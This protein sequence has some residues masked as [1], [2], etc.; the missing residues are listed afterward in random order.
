MHVCE[1]QQT[2]TRPLP[3]K[4]QCHRRG[5][6]ALQIPVRL[7]VV[8]AVHRSVEREPRPAVLPT[9]ALRGQSHAGVPLPPSPRLASVLVLCIMI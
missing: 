5:S 6:L 7:D 1:R 3:R 8:L 2:Q 4:A 9:V